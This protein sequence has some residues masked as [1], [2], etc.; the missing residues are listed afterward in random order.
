L[1]STAASAASY[2]NGNGNG[3]WWWDADVRFRHRVNDSTRDG[4]DVN[5]FSQQEVGGHFGLHGYVV[6]PSLA[7]FVIDTDLSLSKYDRTGDLDSTLLGLGAQINLTP[8]GA[9][10]GRLYFRRRGFDYSA[11]G[12]FDTLTRVSWPDVTT[13]WG[14]G[15]RIRRGAFRGTVFGLDYR[16]TDFVDPQLRQEQLKRHFV[17]WSRSSKNFNH[18]FR[19]RH[20]DWKLG[21]S[22]L[23]FKNYTFN[24]DERGRIAPRWD[25]ESN[26]SGFRQDTSGSGI[27]TTT[28]EYR[29]RNRFLH[30]RANGD[31][32]DLSYNL[33]SLLPVSGQQILGNALSV[34]YRWRPLPGVQVGPFARYTL[35]ESDDLRVSAPSA[36]VVGSWRRQRRLLDTGLTGRVGY[37]LLQRENGVEAMDQTE[38]IYAFTGSVGHGRPEGLRKDFEVEYKVNDLTVARRNLGLDGGLPPLGFPRLSYDGD[39]IRARLGFQ[40]RWDGSHWHTWGQ[41]TLRRSTDVATLEDLEAESYSLFGQFAA[42]RWDINVEGSGTDVLADGQTDQSLRFI[43]GSANWRPV[44]FL[45]FGTL[46]RTDRREIPLLPDVEGQR[47]EVRG[48][49]FLGRLRLEASAFQITEKIDGGSERTNLNLRFTVAMRFG[50]GLPIV[51]GTKRRG[52]IR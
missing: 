49:V 48:T 4:R 36:G 19:L 29:L 52:V 51:T 9:L 44:S 21:T 27:D 47:I 20:R 42:R 46:F 40:H 26:L 22:D 7:N 13:E 39:L 25:W 41:W 6:H 23:A 50:G 16:D 31:L 18:H 1:A 2:G 35:N 43:S 3:R 38:W 45:Y 17:D 12:E 28:D 37:G 33:Q 5:S 11:S 15:L 30:T 24:L 32:L 10:P 8:Q 14:G 34:T